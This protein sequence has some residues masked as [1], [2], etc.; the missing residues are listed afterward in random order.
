ML[1]LRLRHLF[2]PFCENKFRLAVQTSK[3][4]GEKEGVGEEMRKERRERRKLL[5]GRVRSQSLV[6][7]RRRTLGPK[8]S[9]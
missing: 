1:E 3:Q 2:L 5:L 9:T 4:F 7:K 6:S 8:C